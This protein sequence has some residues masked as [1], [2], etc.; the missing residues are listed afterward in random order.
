MLCDGQLFLPFVYLKYELSSSLVPTSVH[1]M[2]DNSFLTPAAG[3]WPE[4]R[5]GIYWLWHYIACVVILMKKMLL[6][7]QFLTPFTKRKC[8]VG[9]TKANEDFWVYGH[10]MACKQQAW[11]SCSSGCSSSHWTQSVSKWALLCFFWYH[12]HATQSMQ[13]RS[14]RR[15]CWSDL[16]AED[17]LSGTNPKTNQGD[18][19]TCRKA[20]L[21]DLGL[22]SLKRCIEDSELAFCFARCRRRPQQH[23]G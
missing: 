15:Q 12:W 23:S 6:R 16:R 1:L 19:T 2:V 4:S 3:Q 11:S 14:P 7:T 13:L 17:E 20:Q 8:C 10:A 5:A 22:K 21:D 18:A 9:N